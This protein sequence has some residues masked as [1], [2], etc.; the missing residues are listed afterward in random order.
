VHVEREHV[1]HPR[2]RRHRVAPDAAEEARH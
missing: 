1:R 2:R